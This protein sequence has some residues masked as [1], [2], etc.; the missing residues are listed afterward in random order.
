MRGRPGPRA[1][2]TRS[3]HR[4][5]HAA[6][7]TPLYKVAPSA[8]EAWCLS[9]RFSVRLGLDAG[10][11]AAGHQALVRSIFK[12]KEAAALSPAKERSAAT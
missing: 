6:R 3:R 4:F 2:W 7:G 9:E 5:E 11:L 1:N 10:T 12:D 8:L